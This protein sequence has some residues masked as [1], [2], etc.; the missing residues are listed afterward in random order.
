MFFNTL[1]QPK[2][3]VN[4]P[5]LLNISVTISEWQALQKAC[6]FTL[7]ECN[8]FKKK[9]IDPETDL[10]TIKNSFP[11]LETLNSKKLLTFSSKDVNDFTNVALEIQ[12]SLPTSISSQ[13]LLLNGQEHEITFDISQN[14]FKMLI[15][16]CCSV[17]RTFTTDIAVDVTVYGRTANFELVHSRAQ[18]IEKLMF[19]AYR[20]NMYLN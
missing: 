10:L 17:T 14:Q 3:L 19:V 16:I 6:A 11:I 13:E 1:K 12:N 2:P 5:D 7:E 8:L 4:T 15:E 20:Y 9:Q 18:M